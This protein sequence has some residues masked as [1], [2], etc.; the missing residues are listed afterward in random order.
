MDLVLLQRYIQD[1]G[2]P[3]VDELREAAHD[4]FSSRAE[5]AEHLGR[6]PRGWPPVVMVCPD[7]PSDYSDAAA[8]AGLTITL[9]EAVLQVNDWISQIDGAAG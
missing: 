8:K 6:I 4:I 2:G 1:I 7:W 9:D 3:T 5:E